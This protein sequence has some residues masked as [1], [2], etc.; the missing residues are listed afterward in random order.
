VERGI[1]LETN[2]YAPGLA[3]LLSDYDPSD[4]WKKKDDGVA[5]RAF[6]E[7][8]TFQLDLSST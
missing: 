2:D 3:K 6:F 7:N 1:N 5:M 8:S 4:P